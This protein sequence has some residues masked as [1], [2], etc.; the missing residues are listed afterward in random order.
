M[1][2]LRELVVALLLVSGFASATYQAQDEMASKVAPIKG[3]AIRDGDEWSLPTKGK[4]TPKQM[5]NNVKNFERLGLCYSYKGINMDDRRNIGICTK[6]CAANPDEN[7][8]TRAGQRSRNR[9]RRGEEAGL[10]ISARAIDH[11]EALKSMKGV[12]VCISTILN[13]HQPLSNNSG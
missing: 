12:S 4:A 1:K 2:S 5:E 10:S 3:V 11:D 7:K 8:K 13:T 6:Y 9:R